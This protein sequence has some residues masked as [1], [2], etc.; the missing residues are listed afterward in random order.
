MTYEGHTN[1]ATA[2]GFQRD[3]KWMYSGSEDKT[4][5]I[6]DLRCVCVC[7]CEWSSDL[8]SSC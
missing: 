2:I 4:V 6:W 3:G 8:L 1:N 7:V 5:K